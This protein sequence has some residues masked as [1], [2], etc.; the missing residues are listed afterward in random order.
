MSKKSLYNL[1]LKLQNVEKFEILSK[2]GEDTVANDF[3]VT[4][5]EIQRKIQVDYIMKL[6]NEEFLKILN[7]SGP[8]FLLNYNFDVKEISLSFGVRKK[9]I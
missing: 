7:V 4:D 8:F 5:T 9:F 6:G 3:Y 1:N 2:L